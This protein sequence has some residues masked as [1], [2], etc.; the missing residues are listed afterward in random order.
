MLEN[1]ELSGYDTPTPIQK[2]TIPAITQGYDVIGIA[3]TGKYIF[4]L[5]RDRLT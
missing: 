4:L 5:L 1:V 3:Q 2:Y